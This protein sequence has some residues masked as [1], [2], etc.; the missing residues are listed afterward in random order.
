MTRHAI[1]L[2]VF[3]ALL[4]CAAS[5]RAQDPAAKPPL[6]ITA[7][8]ALEWH[9]KDQ[10]FIARDNAVA[11]QGDTTVAAAT[12]TADYR[13]E[14]GKGFDISRITADGNVVIS[15][16]D[17]HAYGAHAVYDLQTGLATMTGESLKMVSPDQTVTARERFEYNVSAGRLTAKG[18]A[19]VTRKNDRGEINTLEADTITALLQDTPEGKRT[20]Q[21]LEADGHVV[22]TTPTE[23]VTG[24]HGLYRA[25]NNTAEL[26]GGVTIKRGP[27]ILQGEKATVDLNTNTSRMFGSGGETGRVRGVFYPESERKK[28]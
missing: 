24:N 18:N 23:I 5:T 4:L 2:S 17:S 15:A 28:P 7:D 11:K 8:R 10:R 21:S 26:T 25:D 22:I 3:L 19:S 20:L 14:K 16:R 13:E 6:E 12:L 1:L 9:R 27:N